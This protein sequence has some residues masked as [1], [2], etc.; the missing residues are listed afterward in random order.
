MLLYSQLFL[1]SIRWDFNST[2]YICFASLQQRFATLR[3]ICPESS[4]HGLRIANSPWKVHRTKNNEV[5]VTKLSST[6]S[7]STKIWRKKNS[8]CR[9]KKKLGAL[10]EDRNFS[11]ILKMP[12]ARAPVKV[13]RRYMRGYT[14]YFSASSIIYDRR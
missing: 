11:W 3:I 2:N 9:N 13:S 10:I 7:G 6:W 8:G 4:H 12:A 5:A 1:E 14:S